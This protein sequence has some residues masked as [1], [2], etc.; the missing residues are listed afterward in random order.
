MK[1]RLKI[2]CVL[3]VI[4]L[5]VSMPYI[6]AYMVRQNRVSNEVVPAQISCKVN[7]T[8]TDN[9]KTDIS[10]MNTGNYPAYIRV[11]LISYWQDSKGNIVGRSSPSVKPTIDTANWL[12]DNVN[13]IYYYKNVVAVGG[14]TKDLLAQDAPIVLGTQTTT[15]NKVDYTYHQVVE[16]HAEAIQAK[17]TSAVTN[18]WP[19]NITGT[20]I[21]SLK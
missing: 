11:K 1:K 8:F 14:E 17:P 18:S 10:V 12:Y 21:T 19:V 3:L 16:V 9:T 15:F 5:L 7:E 4:N 20:T 13:D 2:I 6:I